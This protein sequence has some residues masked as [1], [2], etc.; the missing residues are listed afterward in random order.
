[1][2]G[3]IG[4]MIHDPV[5]GMQMPFP[6]PTEIIFETCLI[7]FPAQSVEQPEYKEDIRLVEGDKRVCFVSTPGHGFFALAT[8][9]DKNNVIGIIIGEEDEGLDEEWQER[10]GWDCAWAPTF[11]R[12]TRAR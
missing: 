2:T 11:P 3:Q 1:M 5:T 8:N 4:Q 12:S 9:L 10:L 6:V 7:S